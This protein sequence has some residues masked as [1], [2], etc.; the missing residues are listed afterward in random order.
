ML[1]NP[2]TPLI[3][4]TFLILLLGGL[5]AMY[6][7][8][9]GKITSTHASIQGMLTIGGCNQCHRGNGISEGCLDCH[10]EIAAQL[11]EGT[12]YHG[13]LLKDNVECG[14]CHAEHMGDDSRLVNA[15]SWGWRQR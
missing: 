3:I 11:R 14:S 1:L 6:S 12:G 15:A 13:F 2:R 4:G 5:L 8:M 10:T 7:P 9:P